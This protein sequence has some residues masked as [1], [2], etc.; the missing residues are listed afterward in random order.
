MLMN[1]VK[2]PL[3]AL[4]VNDLTKVFP[5]NTVA[6]ENVSFSIKQGDFFALLGPN[7][8]GKST[9]L[10]IISALTNKTKGEIKIMGYD[11]DRSPFAARKMLG[12]MPQEVNV[13]AFETPEQILMT[14]AGYFGIPRSK[15]YDSVVAMLKKTDLWEKKDTQVR[16]LSGGMK[17]RLMVARALVHGPKVLILD[18]PTAGV[19]VELRQTMW[20]FIK[21][22]NKQGLTVILTTH[23]LEEAENMCNRIALIHKGRVHTD[24]NMK[25]LLKQVSHNHYVLD[26]AYSVNQKQIETINIG[27]S[28]LVDQFTLEIETDKAITLN[29]IFSELTQK[30]IIVQSIR[31]KSTKLERLFINIARSGRTEKG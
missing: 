1:D 31:T 20:T 6:V 12:V 25:T 9:T 28:T 23:Y 22:L 26:L 15:A 5:P 18:E 13:G 29:D 3:P 4:E 24:M 10:G 30:G 19:D 16:H 14:Q 7:G 17:R 11:I 21:D 2:D 8:A 27:Q